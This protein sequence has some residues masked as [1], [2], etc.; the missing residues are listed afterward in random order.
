MKKLLIILMLLIT[1]NVYADPSVTSV[2]D[3]INGSG[4]GIK[5]TA[6]PADECTLNMAIIESKNTRSA[7]RGETG[8]RTII[9]K[10]NP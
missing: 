8:K 4:F 6:T 9:G 1:V 10:R 7:L 3:T 2:D 5:E